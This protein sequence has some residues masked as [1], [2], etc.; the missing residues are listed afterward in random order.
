MARRNAPPRPGL[1]DSPGARAYREAGVDLAAADESLA[2]IKESVRRTFNA[3]VVSGFGGFGGAIRLPAGM[4]R[5]VI[6]SSIDS[7]GTKVSVAA[8]AGRLDTVGHDI[9]HHCVNDILVTGARPLCFLDYVAFADFTAAQSAQVVLG[10]AAACT[11]LG[12]PLV[13]GETAQLPGVYGAGEFDLVGAVVGVAEEDELL[14]IEDVRAGDLVVALPS[15]GIHTNG[16]SL[17]RKVFA[18]VPLEHVYPELG[19]PLGDELLAP[20]RCYLNDLGDFLP[21]IHALAHITGGGLLDNVP[22]SLPEGL[23]ADLDWGRWQVPAIFEL[24]AELGDVPEDE[25]SRIFNLGI[26]MA[27]F[28]D[29]DT[30]DDLTRAAGAS[31]VGTVQTDDSGERVRIR[32]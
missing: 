16:Y 6:V 31:I 23:R 8:R 24:I 25:M 29:Q 17:V 30:A 3:Q 21:R 11:A 15:N 13:G 26:G 2:A 18:D 12:V 20:H 4:R 27:V 14:D 28:C 19:R 22:R 7:V 9:V 5:P 32:R 1:A 10:V